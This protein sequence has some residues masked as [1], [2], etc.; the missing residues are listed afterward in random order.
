[1]PLTGKATG[2]MVTTR[3]VTTDQSF[4]LSA[5]FNKLLGENFVVH[6]GIIDGHGGGGVE[7][8]AY[9]DRFRVGALAY[10][11]TKRDDKPNPRYRFITSFQ[12]WKGIYAQA[13]VQDIGN[14]DLRTV[15]VGGGIRW[16]DDDIKKLL[17]LATAGK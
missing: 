9:E 11:F 3:T 7:F 12:F 2:P 8:R 15:F 6:A 4:G 10:D 5:E 17:G 14:P 16:K 1:M 13:G